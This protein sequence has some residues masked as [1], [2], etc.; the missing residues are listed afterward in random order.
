MACVCLETRPIRCIVKTMQPSGQ[1]R[2]IVSISALGKAEN[3]A[4]DPVEPG[5]YATN[6]GRLNRCT[7]HGRFNQS[8]IDVR[9]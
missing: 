7:G 4:A 1:L 9:R 3:L 8:S 5:Q 6:H 2:L